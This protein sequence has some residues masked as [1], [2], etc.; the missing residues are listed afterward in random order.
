VIPIDLPTRTS[1]SNLH[2][3]HRID[4]VGST[5]KVF[6]LVIRRILA[7][8]ALVLLLTPALLA[9]ST[10]PNLNTSSGPGFDLFTAS[11][12][13]QNGPP[14]FPEVFIGLPAVQ[15]G[16]TQTLDLSHANNPLLNSSIQGPPITPQDFSLFWGMQTGPPISEAQG[17]PIFQYTFGQQTPDANGDYTWTAVLI[18]TLVDNPT[19]IAN[20]TGTFHIDPSAGTISN[21]GLQ[22]G[23]PIRQAQTFQINFTF[24]PTTQLGDPPMSFTLFEIDP[25][26]VSTQLSFAP[27]S[28]PETGSLAL[29]GSGIAGIFA[30]RRKLVK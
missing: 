25:N 29:L 22:A 20:F 4:F 11:P 23:P 1:A 13:E 14:I 24:T 8:L 21:W 19:P 6:T 30:M 7:A 26:G 28:V 17:P 3:L 15:A 10:V 2:S 27:A 9:D 12:F 18:P 5:R 16:G